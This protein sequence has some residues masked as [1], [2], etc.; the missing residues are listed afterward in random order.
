[1]KSKEILWLGVNPTADEIIDLHASHNKCF[2]RCIY[3]DGKI[4]YAMECE[5][6]TMAYIFQQILIITADLVSLAHTNVIYKTKPIENLITD[7][8]S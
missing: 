7:I 6:L 1:M 3:H 5:N 4:R 2:N 8:I